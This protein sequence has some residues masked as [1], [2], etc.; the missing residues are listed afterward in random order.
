MI[1]KFNF[2][3]SRNLPVRGFGQYNAFMRALIN[4][5]GGYLVFARY[6]HFNG[7][8]QCKVNVMRPEMIALFP[9]NIPSFTQ[10]RFA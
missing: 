2:N 1:F 4:P 5:T 9:F 3:K 10:M 6:T 7:V 8:G